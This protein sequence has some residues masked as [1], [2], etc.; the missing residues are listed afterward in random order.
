MAISINSRYYTWHD[1]EFSLILEGKA[2]EIVI[3]INELSWDHSV[4]KTNVYGA[5]RAPI[6]QSRGAYQP[7]EGTMGIFKSYWEDLKSRIGEGYLD[8]DFSLA[9]KYSTGT[10]PIQ[11]TKIEGTFVGEAEALTPSAEAIVVPVRYLPTLIE[12]NG[13]R[14]YSDSF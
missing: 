6:A 8:A 2:R 5:G 1:L 10:E 11:E 7:Q 9:I 14:P 13:R 4:E 12:I 3:A